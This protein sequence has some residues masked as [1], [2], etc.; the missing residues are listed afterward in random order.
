M[1][2]TVFRIC[3]PFVQAYM[4]TLQVRNRKQSVVSSPLEEEQVEFGIDFTQ[5]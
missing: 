5:K 3:E 1:E 2:S 4:L